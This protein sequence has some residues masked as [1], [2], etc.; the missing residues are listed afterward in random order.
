VGNSLMELNMISTQEQ[1]SYGS[2][3][4]FEILPSSLKLLH[5]RIWSNRNESRYAIAIPLPRQYQG[6]IF[7]NLQL[8]EFSKKLITQVE[9]RHDCVLDQFYEVNVQYTLHHLRVI[10][11]R[12]FSFSMAVSWANFMIE[13]NSYFRMIKPMQFLHHHGEYSETSNDEF[14]WIV[15]AF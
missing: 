13:V 12:F 8:E 6:D 10:L 9:S 11:S 15:G 5:I 14:N 1:S 7:M 2:M 4:S 3:Y